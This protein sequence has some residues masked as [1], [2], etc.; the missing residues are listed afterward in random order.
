MKKVIRLTEKE[1]THLVN[2]VIKEQIEMDVEDNEFVQVNNNKVIIKHA[3]ANT[4]QEVLNNIPEGVFFIRIKSCE[5]ADFS[6][7]DLCSLKRLLMVT[8]TNTP[9][10]FEDVVDCP[11][12]K[13]KEG[14]YEMGVEPEY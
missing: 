4:V 8:I 10:N 5:E 3:S 12:N 2:R 9:N 6:D 14:Q 1:L 11:Y 7:V 13:I